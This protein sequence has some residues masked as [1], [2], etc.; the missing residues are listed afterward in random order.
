M[1]WTLNAAPTSPDARPSVSPD[2]NA[3]ELQA[4]RRTAIAT[5]A[6]SEVILASRPIDLDDKALYAKQAAELK[7]IAC[8]SGLFGSTLVKLL[9]C[10]QSTSA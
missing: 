3:P 1:G 10:N 5:H 2:A 7:A 4:R 9:R 6:P 8:R